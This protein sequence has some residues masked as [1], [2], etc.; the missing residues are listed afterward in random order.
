MKDNFISFKKPLL[1]QEMQG[2]IQASI[3]SGAFWPGDKLPS[4]RE[5]IDQLE[6]SRVTVREA[7]PARQS[8]GVIEC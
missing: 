2:K 3:N 1:F 4:E 7:L 6:V 8:Q 5:L